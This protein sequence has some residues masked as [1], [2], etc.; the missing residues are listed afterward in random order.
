MSV[1]WRN[2]KTGDIY[3]KFGDGIDTTNLRDS[4]PVVIYLRNQKIFVRERNEF[5]EKFE[6]IVRV[7]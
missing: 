3:I 4:I 1:H 2:K 6:Q 7:E 5:L